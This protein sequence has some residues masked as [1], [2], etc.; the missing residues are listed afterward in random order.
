MTSTMLPEAAPRLAADNRERRQKQHS[1][2]VFPQGNFQQAG[3][4]HFA[5]G[6]VVRLYADPANAGVSS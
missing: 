4:D 5:S 3:L 6:Q 2:V 1:L